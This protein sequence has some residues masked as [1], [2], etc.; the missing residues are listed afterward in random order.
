MTKSGTASGR[1]TVDR[2]IQNYS[3]LRLL[4]LLLLLLLLQL[5]ASVMTVRYRS[6]TS[7]EAEQLDGRVVDKPR[8]RAGRDDASKWR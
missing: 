1:R 2:S 3:W 7:H 4:A 6:D 5:L 8:G